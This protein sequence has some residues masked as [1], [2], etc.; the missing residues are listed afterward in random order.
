[1]AA[2]RAILST[3]S[4]LAQARPGPAAAR[5]W[6]AA[7]AQDVAAAPWEGA[8]AHAGPEPRL[9]DLLSDPLVRL[10]MRA[11]RIDPADVRRLLGRR[12]HPTVM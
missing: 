3:L 6:H 12:R 5:G 1:M 9:E 7:G 4:G 10:L 11:D 2:V 8:Y